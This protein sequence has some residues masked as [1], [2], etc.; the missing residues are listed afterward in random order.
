[1]LFIG[2]E[3]PGLAGAS[4]SKRAVGDV[5]ER[6]GAASSAAPS[7]IG[8]YQRADAHSGY[9]ITLLMIM[10]HQRADISG[11]FISLGLHVL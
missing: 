7:S 2:A 8:P 10:T 1:M 4:H 3:L 9:S 5:A 6:S 11:Y